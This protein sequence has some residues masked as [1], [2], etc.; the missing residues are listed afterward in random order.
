[1]KTLFS[2]FLFSMAI[3]CF[4]QYFS[5]DLTD[6]SV[7]ITWLGLDFTQAKVIVKPD[8]EVDGERLPFLPNI[9]NDKV[10]SEENKYPL[11]KAFHRS[12]I[13]RSVD[14][15]KVL[16]SNFDGEQMMTQE[17]YLLYSYNIKSAFSKYNLEGLNEGIG[18]VFLVEAIDYAHKEFSGYM[19]PIDLVEKRIMK[20]YYLKTLFPF[21]LEED[22]LIEPF[23]Q[24]LL[25]YADKLDEKK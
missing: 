16:N 23:R 12:S 18:M 6:E 3:S 8:M 10:V 24:I 7:P 17:L 4:G 15:M 13:T 25:Q 14:M 22:E 20:T 9:W 19:I 21:D 11:K 2:A 5:T 1:M